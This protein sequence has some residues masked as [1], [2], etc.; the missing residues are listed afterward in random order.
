M[1]DGEVYWAGGRRWKRIL[2]SGTILG[3]YFNNCVLGVTRYV[4]GPPFAGAW[5]LKSFD[6]QLATASS[7]DNLHG[8]QLAMGMELPPSIAEMER[9]EP[10]FPMAWAKQAGVLGLRMYPPWA[11]FQL[12]VERALVF[13]GRRLIAG[14]QNY[15]TSGKDGYLALVFEE[16][17]PAGDDEGAEVS[18]PG[19]MGELSAAAAAARGS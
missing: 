4:A 14:M 2:G 7:T 13:N 16:L 17:T 1:T 9:M 10:V 8:L 18:R 5:L 15:G 11:P 19:I 12:H 6:W 3:L